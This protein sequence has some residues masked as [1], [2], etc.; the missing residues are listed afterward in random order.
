MGKKENRENKFYLMSR[1]YERNEIWKKNKTNNF[2]MQLFWNYSKRAHTSCTIVCCHQHIGIYSVSFSFS[3][4]FS[5][6]VFIYVVG[7]TFYSYRK[8]NMYWM[9]LQRYPTNEVGSRVSI[10]VAALNKIG[11]F[12]FFHMKKKKKKSSNSFENGRQ[13]VHWSKFHSHSQQR[14]KMNF[15]ILFWKRWT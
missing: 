7:F 4:S 1:R 8:L 15:Y 5:L 9:Y 13:K 11:F 6:Q 14:N 10:A 12:L 3:F 2:H